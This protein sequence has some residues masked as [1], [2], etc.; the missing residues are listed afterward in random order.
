MVLPIAA[1]M[2]VLLVSFGA[3][4]YCISL[5]PEFTPEQVEII[6]EAWENEASFINLAQA[7]GV[8][9]SVLQECHVA[10]SKY[11]SPDYIPVLSKEEDAKLLQRRLL[12]STAE[13]DDEA[14]ARMLAA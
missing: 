8:D 10:E 5:R 13:L 3:I 12:Q 9:P 1:I 2:T 11:L 4:A 6:K 7:E 14:R